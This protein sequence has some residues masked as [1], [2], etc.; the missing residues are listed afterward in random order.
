MDAYRPNFSLGKS[1][2]VHPVTR[3]SLLLNS[4]L[5]R[6]RVPI[7]HR[8][9][10]DQ[11][12][13]DGD[14]GGLVPTILT[15]PPL[16][17]EVSWED[18]VSFGA[19]WRPEPSA[20]YPLP[21]PLELAALSTVDHDS[22]SV[23]C[24]RLAELS[25]YFVL[26]DSQRHRSAVAAAILAGNGPVRPRVSEA[27]GSGVRPAPARRQGEGP[28]PRGGDNV[29]TPAAAPAD[30][31]D[32]DD[33]DVFRP[34]RATTPTPAPRRGASRSRP[35]SALRGSSRADARSRG[36]IDVR[37]PRASARRSRSRSG[38]RPSAPAVV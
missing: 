22:D 7:D 16:P 10:S 3:T 12:P 19:F 34:A 35:G 26:W 15:F 28:S 33:D 4:I 2:Y 1:S 20:V 31:H 37:R 8:G 32:D 21:D 5:G 38:T 14:E 24:A 25:H 36:G 23:A 13:F 29:N 27:G 6:G 9:D 30:H 11:G 17:E 18:V